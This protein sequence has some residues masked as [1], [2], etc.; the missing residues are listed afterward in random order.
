MAEEPERGPQPEQGPGRSAESASER[1][2]EQREAAIERFAD[3]RDA[4]ADRVSG[5]KAVASQR[6]ADARQVAT[7]RVA[8][9]KE[10]ATERVFDAKEAAA[11]FIARQKPRFRGRSH[12]WAFFLFLGLGVT[13]ILAAQ[14]ARAQVATGIYAASLV[15]L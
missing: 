15:A 2:A 14:G 4:A 3:R 8:D 12:E 7:E 13:L 9:A 11:E 5:A 6:A 1:L 10:A